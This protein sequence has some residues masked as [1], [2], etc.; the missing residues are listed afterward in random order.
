MHSESLHGNLTM[1]DTLSRLTSRLTSCYRGS[2]PTLLCRYLGHRSIDT[3]ARSALS[4][5]FGNIQMT[6]S[7]PPARTSSRKVSEAV[8]EHSQT[9][10]EHSQPP[11]CM[12]QFLGASAKLLANK[13]R[14]TRPRLDAVSL[15][16]SM[17]H[18]WTTIDDDRWT[19][20]TPKPKWLEKQ[21]NQNLPEHSQIQ[22]FPLA[23]LC[24][25]CQETNAFFS[26]TSHSDV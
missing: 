20:P 23:L 1:I 3:T 13:C 6:P 8:P 9:P 16:Q 21:H 11:N 18:S 7:C 22:R 5:V 4:R 14:V 15:N 26:M 24:P 25:S 12:E 19:R 17:A 2:L 10:Q